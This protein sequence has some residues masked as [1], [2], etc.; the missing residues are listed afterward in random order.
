MELIKNFV[1]DFILSSVLTAIVYIIL[2]YFFTIENE[3]IPYVLAIFFAFIFVFSV[4]I[5][6]FMF[7]LKTKIDLLNSQLEKLS[8]FDEVANVYK[9]LYV[10]DIL[11]K[12]FN[13]AKRENLPLSVMIIDID[14]FKEINK[15]FTHEVGDK[16]LKNIGKVLKKEVRGMDVVG[17]FGGDE[18]IVA[19]FSKQNDFLKLAN[20]IQNKIKNHLINGYN[21]Q[22]ST[23]IGISEFK[24]SDNFDTLI[25]RA[26]EAIFLAKQKGGNRV[27][28]LEHFLLFE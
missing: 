27:D 15:N 23:S 20:R 9:R 28:Y 14:N 5:S 24:S 22:I 16:I 26:E 25:K 3:I 2:K 19:G 7:K 10:V 11:E 17:R 1:K 12:Y 18:F 6:F 8:K 13:I 21:I 4:F